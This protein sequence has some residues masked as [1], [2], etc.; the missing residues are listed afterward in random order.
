MLGFLQ[1]IIS[2]NLLQT[3]MLQQIIGKHISN[4]PISAGLRQEYTK[5]QYLNKPNNK[6]TRQIQL[7]KTAVLMR[8]TAILANM[9]NIKTIIS[10]TLAIEETKVANNARNSS[11][12]A[13]TS[14]KFKRTGNLKKMSGKGSAGGKFNLLR[15]NPRST[16]RRYSVRFGYRRNW[17]SSIWF[18]ADS[19]GKGGGGL[20][21]GGLGSL[22]SAA[23][24]SRLSRIF[25]DMDFTAGFQRMG[26][27]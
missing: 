5:A 1:N 9:N 22:S 11:K 2:T 12:L 4:K 3:T 17:I 10:K 16:A 23:R 14:S 20:L 13:D 6:I 15:G 7:G 27:C 18:K 19:V 8:L 25:T 21:K 24:R 26:K